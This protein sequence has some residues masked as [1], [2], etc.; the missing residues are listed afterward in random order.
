[1][2]FSELK[3]EGLI[4]KFEVRSSKDERTRKRVR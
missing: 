3:K 4:T 1:M 2:F